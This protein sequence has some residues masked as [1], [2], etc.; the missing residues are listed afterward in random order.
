MGNTNKKNETKVPEIMNDGSASLLLFKFTELARTYNNSHYIA[1]KLSV[2]L[3][4]NE[5]TGQYENP[6]IIELLKIQNEHPSRQHRHVANALKIY[7]NG[8]CC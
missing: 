5:I 2:Y 3:E 4:N 1:G 6:I 8:P 7:K